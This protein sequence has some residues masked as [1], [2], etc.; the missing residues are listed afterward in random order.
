MRSSEVLLLQICIPP[1]K[2]FRRYWAPASNWRRGYSSSIC[3]DLFPHYYS[4]IR[5]SRQN[6]II[7]WPSSIPSALR[8]ALRYK[9]RSARLILLRHWSKREIDKL[10]LI[11]FRWKFAYVRLHSP[12]H[13]SCESSLDRGTDEVGYHAGR[14]GLLRLCQIR[15]VFKRDNSCLVL[16]CA[17]DWFNMALGVCM[18]V[19]TPKER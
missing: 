11:L 15:L 17:C 4:K 1:S 12:R 7:V 13:G 18:R 16:N 9:A 19:T 6:C 8:Q 5:S 14:Y 10:T 2:R 3:D